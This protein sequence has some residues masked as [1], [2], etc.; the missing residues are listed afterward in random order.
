LLSDYGFKTPN[1]IN[2]KKV[3]KFNDLIEDLKNNNEFESDPLKQS[4]I[5][6]I[7]NN[8]KAFEGIV[9]NVFSQYGIKA[10]VKKFS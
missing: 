5:N 6:D 7:C 2:S 10:N 9:A 4:I 1:D 8:P 3:S